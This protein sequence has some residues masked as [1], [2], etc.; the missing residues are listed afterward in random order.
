MPFTFLTEDGTGLVAATS[1]VSVEEADDII[2]V[3]IHADARWTVLD[4]AIKEKLLSWA[5]RYLDTNARW[6]GERVSSTS[7][8]RWPRKG[9]CDRDDFE[10]AEDVIPKQLKIAAASMATYLIAQDRSTER[11]QDALISLKADVVELEFAEGYR[12]PKV[13]SHI[14]ELI[15][16]LG[17]IT[18]GTRVRFGRIIK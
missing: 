18:S 12:L 10:I 14:N 7:G 15:S 4:E 3:N 1:Y 9:V 2:A 16:G 13:P 8:L 6:Y 17:R 5:S 11:P